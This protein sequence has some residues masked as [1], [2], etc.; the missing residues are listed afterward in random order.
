MSTSRLKLV[1]CVILGAL[2]A[3]PDPA[4]AQLDDL[5]LDLFGNK[6][7]SAVPEGKEIVYEAKIVP[8][9]AKPGDEVTL[10]LTATVA[11]G[12]HTFS[13]TQPRKGA[14]PTII[15]IEDDSGLI[16]LGKGFTASRPPH[17]RAETVG[18]TT[19]E[20]EEYTGKITFSRRLQVPD[21][22]ALGEAVIA[23]E[24][25]HQIC[26]DGAG[27]LCV[28][29][30]SPFSVSLKV[31][32]AD[33][34]ASPAAKQG[35]QET[36]FKYRGAT[37]TASLSSGEAAP[38]ETVQL[39][40]EADFEE[41]WHTYGL[42][43]T[44]PDGNGP[45]ATAL[46]IEKQGHLELSPDWSVAPPP[47]GRNEPLFD[48]LKVWE[49]HGKIVW[50]REIEVPADAE[51]GEYPIAGRA[52]Y[53]ACR[54]T[55]CDPPV[56]FTFEGSLTVTDSPKSVP[57][58][59]AVSGPIKGGKAAGFIEE[60][61]EERAAHRKES[62][63]YGTETYAAA[64]HQT[65]Q[66]LAVYLV[67]AFVGGFILNFMPCVL[68]VIAIKVMSFAKQAGEDRSRI[69][70]LNVVYSFGVISVFL[71]LATLAVF[72][73][74]GWGGLFQNANF[75]LIMACIVFA[76]GLSLLGV[77][78]IPMPGMVG[79]AA[80]GQQQEGLLGA[81]STGIFATLLATPCSGPFLGTTL[82]WSITQPAVVV[83][84]VWGMMGLG[85]A[86]PYLVIGWFPAAVKWLPKPGNWM[87]RLK[88]FAGFVLMGT[89][90]FIVHIL[91]DSYTIPALVMLLGIALGLWM[92]GNLYDINSHIRHKTLVR[93]SAGVLTAGIC[94]F[95]YGLTQK[96]ETEL[97]WQPF[98][99]ATLE[100]SLAENKTVL[101]D[102]TADWCLT[103]KRNE[104]F[105][106][107]TQKTLDLVNEHD[108][109]TLYAD[110][111]GES[112]EIKR[113]LDKFK[114]ISVPLT[115]IFP[116]GRPDQPIVLRDLYTQATLLEN[117]EKAVNKSETPT[118]QVSSTDGLRR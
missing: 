60:A 35:P 116:A 105:A 78:E 76:M 34:P 66:S 72:L 109:V 97:P 2:I 46:R 80:G 18:K 12:W 14:T 15:K 63:L 30:E 55:A 88:E 77:F 57:L 8:S 70:A 87:V 16:P 49:H 61:M 56:S 103:C 108:V 81:F 40:V 20:F 50:S 42:D 43:Q 89:V 117:L 44:R 27:G 71:V 86:S 21:D 101:I 58:A 83:Y 36:T 92:I 39:R 104:H 28:Q 90:I 4:S 29:G 45:Y 65:D 17:Q 107:N 6:N 99:G 33:S 68:P 53:Q 82:G 41:G 62:Q 96:G 11:E 25:S 22:I 84:L 106:L 26:K 95:G 85:M 9:E 19:F 73:G 24:V 37:W 102:F 113:W 111:T 110:Y 59:L 10:Q 67:F 5:N 23:G 47:E 91:Q 52:G 32:A 31:A 75:N 51:P 64:E 3:A 69:L 100:A 54:E 79:S 114:S 98:S 48:G 7:A 74:L 13:L 115:V 112:V 118:A 1:V 38:G 94:W 93:V